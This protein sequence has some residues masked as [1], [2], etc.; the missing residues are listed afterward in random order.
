MDI[1]A[2]LI[3][4]TRV[5]SPI[6][7][8]NPK[9][10][11]NSRSSRGFH[12]RV[13]S[14]SRITPCVLGEIAVDARETRTIE[15]PSED[16]IRAR[17]SGET[18][19]S[20]SSETLAGRNEGG[21]AWESSLCSPDLPIEGPRS[22][23]RRFLPVRTGSRRLREPA[24]GFDPCA[25]EPRVRAPAAEEGKAGGMLGRPGTT[26]SESVEVLAGG[27]L[28]SPAD[29]PRATPNARASRPP[30]RSI[31]PP[32]QGFSDST[33]AE[34]TSS[35]SAE[36][37][38]EAFAEDFTERTRSVCGDGSRSPI[39]RPTATHTHALEQ[40]PGAAGRTLV[41]SL[42]RCRSSRVSH[43]WTGHR[44]NRHSLCKFE[45]VRDEA[46]P[47]AQRSAEWAGP[48]KA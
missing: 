35:I 10:A 44:E 25:L 39:L 32:C 27:V 41:V 37:S 5:S 29:G 3:R 46:I 11:S 22:V 40:D 20:G 14:P 33:R 26:G 21:N 12:P 1:S 43:F 4:L 34:G 18:A 23:R 47:T 6:N 38:P 17:R 30:R 48:G 36:A 42:G 24:N 19:L 13:A 15:I 8:K 31:R 9:T 2:D 28:R 7:S 16:E 45:W